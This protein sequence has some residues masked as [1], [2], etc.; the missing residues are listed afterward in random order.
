MVFSQAIRMLEF[1]SDWP[2]D[3]DLELHLVGPEVVAHVARV[4][5]RETPHLRV[6]VADLDQQAL[7]LVLRESG[8]GDGGGEQRGGEQESHGAILSVA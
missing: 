7:R 5:Q 2:V 3:D 1:E 6:F 8:A 4:T